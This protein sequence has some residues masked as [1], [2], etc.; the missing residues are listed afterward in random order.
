MNALGLEEEV[1]W[2]PWLYNAGGEDQVAG[3]VKE[4]DNIAFVTVKVCRLLLLLLL[5]V[6]LQTV[7]ELRNM[8]KGSDRQLCNKFK[9]SAIFLKCW[10]IENLMKNLKIWMSTDNHRSEIRLSAKF[11]WCQ[12][13][14]TTTYFEHCLK[15]MVSYRERSKTLEPVLIV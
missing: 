14:R 11:F 3:F 15:N 10:P 8:R 4:Y 9:L 7:L 5:C 6:F 2:R 13:A 12:D 1:Q